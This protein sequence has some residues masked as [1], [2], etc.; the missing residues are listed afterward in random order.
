MYHKPAVVRSLLLMLVPLLTP[1]GYITTLGAGTDITSYDPR[2]DF[3]GNDRAGRPD[4][5]FCLFRPHAEEDDQ[6]ISYLIWNGD[7]VLDENQQ[8]VRAFNIPLTISSR[9][10]EEG[11]RLEAMLRS[12]PDIQWRDLLAR[13]VRREMLPQSVRTLKNKL[14]MNASRFRIRARL[15]SFHPTDNSEAF[16]NYLLTTMTAE[17]VVKNTTEGLADLS[18]GC[19]EKEFINLLNSEID[20]AEEGQGK[21]AITEASIKQL[22]NKLKR[23]D[24]WAQAQIAWEAQ[25]P[26]PARSIYGEL[27]CNSIEAMFAFRLASLNQLRSDGSLGL[28][29]WYA[30]KNAAPRHHFEDP[31]M[32]EFF[33]GRGD[34]DAH[35]DV[36]DPYGLLSSPTM[37]V[38]QRCLVDFLLEPARM[39]YLRLTLAHDGSDHVF[40]TSSEESYSYQFS[41]LQSAFEEHWTNIGKLG[42]APML[43]AVIK[44]DIHSMTW[45]TE[46][47]PALNLVW[48]ALDSCTRTFQNWQR[49]QAEAQRERLRRKQQAF[50]SVYGEGADDME[51]EEEIESEDDIDSREGEGVVEDDR[52]EEDEL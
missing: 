43:P 47:I 44:L 27:D 45:N 37:S 17:M 21:K 28:Q 22:K 36:N 26:V 35:A 40:T 31:R 32:L 18:K 2:Y 23:A 9:I 10:G 11:A 20:D 4:C 5:L 29:A 48:Q 42:N 12:H 16:I 19:D 25:N 30:L 51:T 50:D 7:V 52:M 49:Y 15:L 8:P 34:R 1:V 6:S 41:E 33:G 39:Q 13:I 46:A 38:E 14:N 24:T 3:G